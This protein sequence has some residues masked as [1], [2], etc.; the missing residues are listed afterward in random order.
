MLHFFRNLFS[1]KPRPAHKEYYLFEARCLRCG[2]ILQGRVDL[3]NDL[4]VDYEGD[5]AVYH[6]RKVLMGD[7]KNLCFA[8]VEVS[9]K[10]NAGHSKVLDR[11]IVGG[12]FVGEAQK[13]AG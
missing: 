13:A 2:E 5:Q 8:Q 1:G 11:Q 9:L 12:T 7:G 4:S 6:C 3:A 10:F